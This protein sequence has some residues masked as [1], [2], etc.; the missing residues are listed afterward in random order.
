MAIYYY[1][2]SDVTDSQMK[3]AVEFL[4][5]FGYQQHPTMDT[6]YYIGDGKNMVTFGS[7]RHLIQMEFWDT[8]NYR[9]TFQ[10][11]L[12]KFRTIFKVS[13]YALDLGCEKMS[14]QLNLEGLV[15]RE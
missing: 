13:S 3:E 6:S 9:D 2:E 1:F 11:I 5:V 8:E 14:N 15:R 7:D 4:T 12:D 10:Q